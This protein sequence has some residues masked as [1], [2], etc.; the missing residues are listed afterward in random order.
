MTLAVVAVGLQDLSDHGV[1]L[2]FDLTHSG[3]HGKLAVM[4]I[5]LKLGNS[6]SLLLFLL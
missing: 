4:N 5:G 3:L 2:I 6:F 1:E